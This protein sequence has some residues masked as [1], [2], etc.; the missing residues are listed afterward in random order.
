MHVGDIGAGNITKLCNQIIVAINISAVGEALLL[1]QKGGV[2]PKWF[3]K[4]YGEDW[5]EVLY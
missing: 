5:Q 2:S 3:T 1:A 4:P